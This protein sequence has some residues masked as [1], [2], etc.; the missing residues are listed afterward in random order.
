[1]ARPDRSL[2]RRQRLL[3]VIAKAF[4]E[5]GYRRT[6]TAELARRAGVQETVLYRLW[7]DKKAMFKAAIEYVYRLSEETWERFLLPSGPGEG[8]PTPAERILAYEAGHHGEFGLYRIVFAGLS[9]MDDPEIRGAL[10]R[11]YHRFHR[12]IR[13]RIAEHHALREGG[14]SLP[15]AELCAWA[16]VGLGTVANIGRELGLL[17][18][19]RRR[20][21]IERIGAFLLEGSREAE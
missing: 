5:R 18:A 10:R 6:T 15:E 9:E 14:G 8:G 20:A 17:G 3:P 12:F 1:M 11:M 13:E 2:E 4:A 7:P 19:R 21:L 16:V